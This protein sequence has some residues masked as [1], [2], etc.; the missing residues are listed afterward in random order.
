MAGF[1]A[2]NLLRGD[3]DFWYAEQYPH[4]TAAGLVLDVRGP[5]EYDAWHIPEAVNIPLQELRGRLDELPRSR[6]IYVY[7]RVGFRSYL[8]H[9]ILVQE[10]FEH[11][12]TLAGGSKTFSSHHITELT[13]GRPGAPFVAHAEEAMALLRDALKY[14]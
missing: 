6:P 8:A 13:T 3:V 12:A 7:C 5:A 14:A 4:E 10:G 2:S 11:V 9:R 1:V